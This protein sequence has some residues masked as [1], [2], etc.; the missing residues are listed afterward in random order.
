MYT[1]YELIEATFNPKKLKD[2]NKATAKSGFI[3]LKKIT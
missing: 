3:F 1:F 2:I